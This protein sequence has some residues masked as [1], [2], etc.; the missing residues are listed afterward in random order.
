MKTIALRMCLVVLC[1]ALTAPALSATPMGNLSEDF[2]SN[3]DATRWSFSNGPE[4]PGADGSFSRS[5]DAARSGEFGG[6]LQF[7]FRAGGRYVGAYLPLKDAPEVAAL[8]LWMKKPRGTAVTVRY[9][10]QTNQT[11]Q[12][13][14][15]VPDDQWVKLLIPLSDWSGHWGGADDGKVHGAPTQIG[16]LA[17][18]GSLKQGALLFDE[19]ELVPGTSDKMLGTRTT[20]YSAAQFAAD[21]G[22][23][24][25][26]RGPAAASRLDGRTLHY[27]FSGGATS[28][29]IVPPESSLLGNPEQIRIR[30]R[31]SAPS[32]PVRLLIATHFMTF[33]TTVGEFESVSKEGDQFSELVVEAPPG[34]GWTWHGGENDGKRHGPLRLRGIFLEA[35]DKQDSGT[36]ELLEIGVKTSCAAN[37]CCVLTADCPSSGATRA[38]VAQLRSLMPQSA[39]G[40]LECHIRDWSGKLIAHHTQTVQLASDATPQRLAFA[41]PPGDFPYLEAEFQLDVA[42]QLVPRTQAYYVRPLAPRPTSPLDTS[43]P[44][45]MGLYLYRF[46]N[47]Q[48]SLKTMDSMARMGSQ[49]GIKWSREEFNWARIETQRGEFDWSFYDNL[50]KTAQR[51]GISVYGLLGYWARWTQPYTPEGIDDYCRFAAAAARRYRGTINHWEVYNEPNIFFWQGPPDMYADLLTKAYQAIK[52]ANPD[53]EVLGCSTAG[54]DTKFIKRTMELGAPFDSLTIHPYRRHL[55]D[56]EFVSELKKAAE[57][58]QQ[59]DGTPRPIWITEMG[60]GTHTY[61]NS[62][63]SDFQVTTQREQACLIAR[64]YLDVIA[65]GVVANTCWYDF[66]NDGSDPFNFEHNMGI[67]TH[68]FRAKPAYQAYATLAEVL[69]SLSFDRELH[70]G[71]DI[72]A[73]QFSNHDNTKQLIALWTLGEDETI[74]LPIGGNANKV[75]AVNLMGSSQPLS[76][77]NGAIRVQL[78]RETPVM[79]SWQSSSK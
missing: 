47:D 6:A 50:V 18:N 65:S 56:R 33:E 44:F 25:S 69:H 41:L 70:L 35:G 43:S 72:I 48:H 26:S 54:I 28:I 11:L 52:E 14:V 55:D 2:D 22:W 24:M 42:G 77:T 68:D 23:R 73:Y 37:R 32:H 46:G 5:H 13:S 17:E 19:L 45:G 74:S 62:A 38:F 67:I 7:D 8:H 71:D 59:S 61:H 79:V 40:T 1:F 76:P 60:W 15:W 10:D 49:A 29:G 27:D 36:L 16:L 64:T 21:E 51:H 57:I 31:G 58:V 53:A 66:R 34:D 20:E 78:Q 39:E 75:T 4:F 9:T 63:A 3:W 12:K 30:V